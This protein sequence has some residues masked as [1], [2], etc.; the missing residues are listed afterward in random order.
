MK[1]RPMS[2]PS[3]VDGIGAFADR[4][5]GFLLDQ[6]GVIHD[7]RRALPAALAALNEL[8]RRNKRLVVLSNSGR[9]AALNRRRLAEMGFNV[10]MF[11]AVVTSGE[12]AWQVLKHR[13]LPGL[14]DLGRR[15]LLFTIGGD[16]GVVEDLGLE[17]VEGPEQADFLFLTGT[18]IPPLTLDD[19]RAVLER[20]AARGLPMVCSNPDHVAP[21]GTEL[22]IAP[23]TIAAMYEAMGGAVRYVGKPHA[24]IYG[25]CLD[26]LD[27]L[28]LG[29]I[30][31]VGDSLEHD[32]K[33]A[34]NVGIA[35]CLL[36]GGIHAGEFP[37]DAAP[38][39][40]ERHLAK[41]IEQHAATP[42]WVAP[43]LAW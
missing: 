1:A 20:A 24:P 3:F 23:G 29:E 21:S 38:V 7:G 36:T 26:A 22:V 32:I 41:L 16:L 40:R 11:D 42:D 14:G 6:W 33:G 5:Q 31:A 10:A 2:T 15:C 25:A 30:V 43:R 18:E 8:K 37:R 13:S 27:G 17:L 28:D 19:Y 39:E 35:S 9:R 34:N 4:Y 12:A